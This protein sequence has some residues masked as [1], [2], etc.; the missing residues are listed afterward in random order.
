MRFLVVALLLA[1]GCYKTVRIDDP[2]GAPLPW[3]GGFALPEGRCVEAYGVDLLFVIDNSDS[4]SEEQASLASQ[5]PAFVRA[6]VMPPDADG[7]GNPDW[8]PI[9]DLQVG[10][11]TTDMGVGGV[12]GLPTCSERPDFGDDAVLRTVGAL[13]PSCSAMYPTFLAFAAGA[14]APEEFAFQVGCLTT[15]GIGG[16]GF[17]QPLE[18]MLKALSPARPTSYTGSSYVPPRFFLDTSGHGDGANA[19]FVRN[20]TLLAVVMVTDEEDCSIHDS[21]LFNPDPDSPYGATSLN[22]RCFAHARDAVHPVSRYITGLTA[23]R[24]N[25]PDLVAFGVIAGV[26]VDLVESMP[27][28]LDYERMLRDERMIEQIDPAPPPPILPGDRL[29]PSCSSASGEAFPPRRLV[30]VARGIG[31]GRSTVQS[32]CDPS[33]GPA[34][35]AI[36]RLVG[37]RACLRY[38]E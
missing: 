12:L 2:D 30:E 13:M 19:G 5:L 37:T 4:M 22:L 29:L 20:D 23:L 21:E 34:A 14:T 17:E 27:D 16:C 15:A 33:F 8:L 6:L 26:P 24:P 36:G 28:A 3:D 11:V 10:V 31:P 38:A 1:S 25:R 7:D 35:A 9:T 32:I 18:A